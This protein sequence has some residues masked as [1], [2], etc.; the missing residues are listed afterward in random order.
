MGKTRYSVIKS[1]LIKILIH[2]PSSTED[3]IR[4]IPT[5]GGQLHPRKHRK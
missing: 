3:S 1:N 5:H 2:K 4:K